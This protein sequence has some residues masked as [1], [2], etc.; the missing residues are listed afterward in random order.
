MPKSSTLTW[1]PSARRLRKDGGRGLG[2]VDDR[3]LG[4]LELEAAGG[5]AGL[6]EHVLDLRDQVGL[7]ELLAREVDGHAQRR[8][9]REIPCAIRSFDGRPLRRTQRP[10]CMI[11]PVSSATG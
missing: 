5:E 11:I 9:G 8:V 1:T 2:V 6:V 4:D 10:S 3:A 7:H